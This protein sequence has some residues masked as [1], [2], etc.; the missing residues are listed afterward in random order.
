MVI[1]IELLQGAAF[2]GTKCPEFDCTDIVPEFPSTSLTKKLE[3]LQ[4]IKL[5]LGGVG[6]APYTLSAFICLAIK[7]EQTF[8]GLKLLGERFNWPLNIDFESLSDR[9]FFDIRPDILEMIQNPIV[10][11]SSSAWNAFSKILRKANTSL[12]QFT[13]SRDSIR[14]DITGKIKHAG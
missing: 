9:V 2:S 11:G 7:Q 4:K 5:G 12:T 8:P 14:F 10:L 3:E 1:F 6:G 13:R